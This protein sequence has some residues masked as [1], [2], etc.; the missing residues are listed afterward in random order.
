MTLH[1]VASDPRGAFEAFNAVTDLVWDVTGQNEGYEN[2]RNSGDIEEARY[3]S[4][5]LNTI[6]K[7]A[8]AVLS[9]PMNAAPLAYLFQNIGVQL[10]LL[11]LG[12]LWALYR[13]GVR[14]LTLALPVLIYDFGT[15]LLL[16]GN[17][18]RFFQFSMAVCLP[19]LV[20]L[21]FASPEKEA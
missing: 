11:L 2:V 8:S 17:D 13:V 16:C 15:M 19:A 1:T 5:R 10:L 18:A 9:A 7:A 21:L 6:G 14:A 3:G 20:A 4:A 12:A